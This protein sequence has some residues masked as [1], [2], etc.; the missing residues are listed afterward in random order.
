[1]PS[2]SK[3]PLVY[4]E[5]S[6]ISYLTARVSPIEKV[7]RDQ[8]A[9]RRW[10]EKEGPK[11]ELFISEIVQDEARDGD[12][13]QS[14]LRAV[15]LAPLRS[16]SATPEAFRL[17]SKLLAAHALPATSST[18]ALHIA[19]AT[20]YGADFLL[21]WNCRHIANSVTLP[22]TIRTI[23]DAGYRPPVIATPAQRLEEDH[24]GQ[25]YP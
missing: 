19:L 25:S 15:I 16:V 14:A 3:K 23:I 11:C 7:A 9:T 18:D 22:V 5:T 6:F 2:S 20:I 24:D 4:L 21:T 17:S 10:W 1:M 13:L 12:P 8:S